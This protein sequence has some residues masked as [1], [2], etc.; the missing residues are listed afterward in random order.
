MVHLQ[1]GQQFK[2]V[3][4]LKDLN[5]KEESGELGLVAKKGSFNATCRD[6]KTSAKSWRFNRNVTSTRYC[7]LVDPKREATAIA[8]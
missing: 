4:Y 6:A 7:N 1:I 8:E 5:K 3:E 2:V